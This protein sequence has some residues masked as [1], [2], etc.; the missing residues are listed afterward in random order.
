MAKKQ[1]KPVPMKSRR[2]G[3]KSAARIKANNEILSKLEKELKI[4]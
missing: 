2:A 4:K 3:L 1:K